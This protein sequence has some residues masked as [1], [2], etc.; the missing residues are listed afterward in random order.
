[1]GWA[2]A[3]AGQ[4]AKKERNMGWAAPVASIVTG[5]GGALI[6]R[7]GQNKALQAQ[8]RATNAQ[9]QYQREQDAGRS[10]RYERAYGAYEKEKAQYDQ[11]R[12]ALL[13]HYGVNF[14]DAPGGAPA[15]GGE[16]RGGMGA[17]GG[18]NVGQL[19]GGGQTA[20][21]GAPVSGAPDAGLGPAGPAGP[22]E[23]GPLVA[24]EDVFDWRRYGV[25]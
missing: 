16:V 15:G 14:G 2:S 11:I 18:M 5:I 13:S 4:Q 19:L 23:P 9:L 10:Q 24:D 12:R 7:S 17:G 22:S 8:E 3:A 21:G 6:G 1:M 25:R 20:I